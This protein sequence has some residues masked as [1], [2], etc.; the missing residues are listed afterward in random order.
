MEET[1]DFTVSKSQTSSLS[2]TSRRFTREEVTKWP[3]SLRNLVAG[4]FAGMSA[5]TIVAPIDRIKIL[6]QVSSARFHLTNVPRVA[7]AI[8]REEGF[9]ALWKGNLTTMVRVFPYSGIQFMVFDGC[10]SFLL[11]RHS[12]DPDRIHDAS[13]GPIFGLS[14]VESLLAG[15]TAG[16]VSVIATYPLDL[17]RAQLAVIKRKRHQQNIGF[18]RLMAKNFNE[19]VSMC[20][21]DEWNRSMCLMMICLSLSFNRVFMVSIGASHQHSWGFYRTPGWHLQ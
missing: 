7:L 2:E 15:S 13:A 9:A 5:K 18:V 3:R 14:P 10:K 8:I 20:K 11:S 6:Y 17:A 1:K 19:S 12:L 21:H 4:G 16:L